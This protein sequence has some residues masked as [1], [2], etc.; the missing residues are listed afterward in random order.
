MAKAC[1]SASMLAIGLAGP[2]ASSSGLSAKAASAAPPKNA[3]A[4]EG[5]DVLRHSLRWVRAEHAWGAF[6]DVNGVSSGRILS[7]PFDKP[8]THRTLLN[9]ANFFQPRANARLK[10]LVGRLVVYAA[11]QTFGKA[12]HVRDLVFV[13]VRVLIAFAVT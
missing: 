5:T 6:S 9:P 12:G 8:L 1:T 10:A 3:M 11:R 2:C 13:V 4:R 7:L